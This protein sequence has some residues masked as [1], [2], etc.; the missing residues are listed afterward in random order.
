MCIHGR[1]LD[2]ECVN[3][4]WGL[5]TLHTEFVHFSIN[6]IRKLCKTYFMGNKNLD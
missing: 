5:I 6:K 2:K 1:L 4:G 3:D